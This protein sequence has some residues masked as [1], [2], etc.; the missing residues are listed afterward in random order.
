MLASTVSFEM[1]LKMAATRDSSATMGRVKKIAVS[2]ATPAVMVRP[3]DCR[4]VGRRM[5]SRVPT[6]VARNVPTA[7]A[8]PTSATAPW[9][10]MSRPKKVV[11][12]APALTAKAK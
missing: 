9:L 12:S 5:R 2:T 8:P 11:A 1:P 3:L 7:S 4:A 10:P 6:A